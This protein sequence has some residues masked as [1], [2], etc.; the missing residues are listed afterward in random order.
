MGWLSD[1]LRGG[2]DELGWD[3]LIRR[4]VDEVARLK[5][6]GARGEL[7]FPMEV[8]VRI[9]V[10]EGSVA[11]IQELVDR[12]ELDREVGAA[13][14]NRCDVAL[15][16]LPHR[17]YLVSAADRT[18]VSA[19]EGAPRAWQIVVDGGDRTGSTLTL[20][21]G[22][23]EVAFGRGEWHGADHHARNDLVVCEHTEFVSRR[24][25]RLYRAGH[26][27]EVASLDQGDQL[28][29]KRATGEAVR[30]SRTSRGRAPVRPGDAIELTDGR[31]G[32]VR[33]LV[34]R[35]AG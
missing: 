22:W 20:P 2:A 6:F 31:A 19:T 11:T 8:V 13:L 7:V 15:D 5:R 25:G 18:T 32:T 9:M 35:V 34:Q 3:D 29:V 30:P 16:Q 12:P 4:V 27:L 10:G 26:V 1:L 23:S 24:A 17:E 21:A 14:A 28:C 33:L